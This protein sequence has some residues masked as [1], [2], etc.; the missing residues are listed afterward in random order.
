MS[1]PIAP[2]SAN[3]FGDLPE[4]LPHELIG[5]LPLVGMQR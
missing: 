1:S 5:F 4:D 3:F 2:A